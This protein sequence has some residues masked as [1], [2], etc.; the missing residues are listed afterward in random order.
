MNL[1]GLRDKAYKTACEHGFHDNELSNEHCLMLVITELS[2]A[3]EADRKGKR[4]DIAK[5]KEWQGNSIALTEEIRKRRFKEDFEAYIKG[6]VEEELAD[7]C[8]RLLDF[9]GLRN[10]NLDD[11]NDGWQDIVNDI[12]PDAAT[13]YT[14]TEEMFAV[15]RNITSQ[16]DSI[17][18]VVCSTLGTLRVICY[19]HKIDL[20]WHIE[21]KMLYNSF[22]DNMHGKKY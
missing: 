17:T 21:Q 1:N 20:E 9:A 11:W 10:I 13:K 14:F 3:V 2:E 15:C 19:V 6:S 16:L 7:A 22:R 5:F 18:N 12:L 8:I 4:S